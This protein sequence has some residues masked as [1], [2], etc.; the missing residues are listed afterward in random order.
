[1]ALSE[2]DKI[3]RILNSINGQDIET[4]RRSVSDEQEDVLLEAMDF[5]VGWRSPHVKIK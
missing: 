3:V 2:D 1:V 4:L 5:L